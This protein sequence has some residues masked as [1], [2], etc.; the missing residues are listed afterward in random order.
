MLSLVTQPNHSHDNS[1]A[2]M[3]KTYNWRG[4]ATMNVCS[5]IQLTQ[6]LIS[7][8]RGSPE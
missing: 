4:Q 3:T 6:V 1:N 8:A 2:N 5:M 7:F